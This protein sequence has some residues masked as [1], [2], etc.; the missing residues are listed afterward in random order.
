MWIGHFP[1]PLKEQCR[2]YS[3]W[4][5]CVVFCD[6][7][8]FSFSFQAFRTFPCFALFSRP[9]CCSGSVSVTEAHAVPL[10]TSAAMCIREADACQTNLLDVIKKKSLDT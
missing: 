5:K 6:K 9:V 2:L 7:T 8:T 4:G 3:L 1:H 10:S